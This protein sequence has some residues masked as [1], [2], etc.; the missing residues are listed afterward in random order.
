VDD[1]HDVHLYCVLT[2]FKENTHKTI[3]PWSLVSSGIVHRGFN[4]ILRKGRTEA[5]K[6]TLLRWNRRPIEV[7]AMWSPLLY[8]LFEMIIDDAIF[9]VVLRDPPVVVLV[10]FGVVQYHV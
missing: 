1:R 2:S 4:L 9:L 5:R 7:H 10:A 3:R 6:A 8:D